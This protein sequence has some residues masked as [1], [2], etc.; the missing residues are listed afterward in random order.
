MATLLALNAQ[1]EYC[2]QGQVLF[3]SWTFPVPQGRAAASS[4]G[5][6]G[7]KTACKALEMKDKEDPGEHSMAGECDTVVKGKGT[8][9]R[10][11]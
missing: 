6:E 10:L 11:V 1:V 4:S 3:N 7:V 5:Y 8:G 2:I 9:N